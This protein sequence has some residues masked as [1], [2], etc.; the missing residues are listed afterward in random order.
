MPKCPYCDEPLPIESA[1]PRATRAPNETVDGVRCLKCGLMIFPAEKDATQTFTVHGQRL[2]GLMI[3][4][5]SLERRLG[6]GSFGE[7]WLA[8][9]ESLGRKVALKLPAAGRFDGNLIYEAKAA[10][11]L[12]H[13]NIVSVY[14]AGIAGGQEFIATEYVEGQT[15][16]DLLSA[17]SLSEEATLRFLV[18]VCEALAHAHTNG[19]IHRDVKPGNILVNSARQPLVADFGLARNVSGRETLSSDGQVLGT[20]YYMSPEQARG[21]T[22]ETDQRSDIYAIGVILFEMLT[23]HLPFRGTVQAVLTQKCENEP[24]SPRTLKPRLGRDI[25]T[26]CLKCL[27]RDASRRYQTALEVA[28]E[29]R[30]ILRQEPIKARPI[31][32]LERG[33]RWC[34]RRPMISGLAASLVLSL[35][36][37][38]IGVSY[39][40]FQAE[41][42]AGRARASLY[43]ARM[44]LI[45]NQLFAGDVSAVRQGLDQIAT[46]P[47]LAPLREFAWRYFDSRTSQL[48][49]VGS[50]GGPVGDLAI[51]NNGQYVASVSEAKGPGHVRVWDAENQELVW[52]LKPDAGRVLCADFSPTRSHIAVGTKDG[53]ARVYTVSEQSAPLMEFKHGPQLTFLCYLPDGKHLATAGVRGPV[54]IWDLKSQQQVN[55]IPTGNLGDT[56]DLRVPAK[57]DFFGVLK[58]DNFLRIRDALTLEKK[59]DIRVDGTVSRFTFL[60][61]G[62]EVA[63]A[64][65]SGKPVTTVYSVADGTIVRRYDHDSQI[66]DLASISGDTTLLASE[67]NGYIVTLAETSSHRVAQIDTHNKSFGRVVV[68]RNG[69]WMGVAGQDGAVRVGRVDSICKQEIFAHPHAVQSVCYLEPNDFIATA[70]VDGQVRRWDTK[71]GEFTVLREAGSG[72]RSAIEFSQKRNCIALADMSDKVELLDAESGEL[73]AKLDLDSEGVGGHQFLPDGDLLVLS[74][75]GRVLRFE[76]TDEI[77]TSGTELVPNRRNDEVALSLDV[78]A[79]EKFVYV[80]DSE[81]LLTTYRS[82]TGDVV[83][84]VAVDQTPVAAI[85]VLDGRDQIVAGTN[86][87]LIVLLDQETMTPVW[88]VKGHIGEINAIEHLHDAASLVTIGRDASIR[89]WEAKPGKRSRRSSGLS[90]K[91]SMWKFAMTNGNCFPGLLRETQ[92][93]GRRSNV[94]G[95]RACVRDLT[96]DFF[97]PTAT[98]P[99]F[100]RK[101]QR[102]SPIGNLRIK[103]RLA[104]CCSTQPLV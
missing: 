100:F 49:T 75:N 8:H 88:K 43:R 97:N 80:G 3:A 73:L 22:K 41:E 21:R 48:T 17:T 20:A 94:R 99:T 52:S 102:A 61:E 71:T 13:P 51:S 32:S 16:M 64:E 86:S 25:E 83:H 82:D 70:T 98:P 19:I 9:D 38:L 34:K 31:T 50:H 54:R 77:E 103:G 35:T 69:K 101:A 65:L 26:V 11:K 30:R 92:G 5:F 6:Q 24:P 45:G 36:S 40:F 18:L 62:T 89:L 67:L 63:V 4:H 72:K 68:S 91:A 37:G 1:E 87:G 28:D 79:D 33:W 90:A 57:G 78:S 10:A 84:T 58:D 27:E 23:G 46:D 44:N 66:G 81:G 85:Q 74:R 29:F 55:E 60:K 2:P 96:A 56:L 39:F 14:E 59:A 76:L 53:W 104:G 93:C 47:A 7:V 42:N 12:N 15:L 95:L